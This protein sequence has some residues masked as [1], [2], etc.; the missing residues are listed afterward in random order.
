MI[1]AILKLILSLFGSTALNA[2]FEYLGSFALK[3]IK[4]PTSEKAKL[5]YKLLKEFDE[6]IDKIL[7]RIKS[8]NPDLQ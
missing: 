2:V 6:E 7:A 1:T 3:A 5:L 4:D 8:A